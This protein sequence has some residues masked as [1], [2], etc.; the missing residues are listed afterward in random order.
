M[1]NNTVVLNSSAEFCNTIDLN[2]F[3]KIQPH[4]VLL[5]INRED[6]QV[7]QC[8]HN[9]SDILS[10]APEKILNQSI[11]Q[12]IPRNDL[13]SDFLLN[14]DRKWKKLAWKVESEE[15]AVWACVH[16]YPL[17]VMLEIEP[18]SETL[19]LS[20]LFDLQQQI[21]MDMQASQTHVSFSELIKT[22]CDQ[23]ML[24]T[25][26]DRVVIYQI[27]KDKTGLVIAETLKSGMDAYLGLR[28]PATDLPKQVH[29][30][31]VKQ[32]MRYIPCADATPVAMIPELNPLTQQ[33]TNVTE[34]YLRMV[35][36]VHVEYMKNMGI[37]SSISLGIVYDNQLWGIISC[38]HK[39]TTYYSVSHRFMLNLISN[40]LSSQLIALENGQTMIFRNSSLQLQ[41]SF[42]QMMFK[43]MS[44]AEV[45]RRHSEQILQLVN[46][47]GMTLFAGGDVHNFGKTPSKL[48]IEELVD[49]LQTQYSE[50]TY[51]TD[52]LAIEFPPAEKYKLDICGLISI[53][54]SSLS[55]YFVLFYRPEKIKEI[56]WAGDPA[57]A[58]IKD[59]SGYSPR[60]SFKRCLKIMKDHSEPWVYH[61]I[62]SAEFV[63]SI[64]KSKILKDYL[65]QQVSHDFLTG[66]L[67]RQS[68]FMMTNAYIA[69]ARREEKPV[70]MMMIDIDHFK[71]INDTYGHTI[72]DKVLVCVAKYLS[73][74][75]R[76][77]DGIFR[78][79]GEE[80]IVVLPGEGREAAYKRAEQLRQ[81][82][83]TM[84]IDFEGKPLPILTV[85]I[86]IAEYPFHGDNI[87]TL[88]DLADQALYEAKASG[89]D[90]VIIANSPSFS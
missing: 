10:V 58:V 29:E 20:E 33:V 17:Y 89:R 40:T 50:Q 75:F 14:K 57:T 16:Q 28:F 32:Y 67:N 66:L 30:M 60:D 81:N 47:G 80:F 8:S 42:S 26:S 5:I 49:F 27:D 76:E 24:I 55:R 25:D 72:G 37:N 77:Y 39:Q 12:F 35:V 1:D 63:A 87:Q 45:V 86:G 61:D 48:E 38:H 71:K 84:K 3:N 36:P 41:N 74:N 69:R 52:A 83:K 54:I 53:P 13:Y 73:D 19:N 21:L 44:L 22:I 51:V 82:L 65:Q 68:L 15:R 62:T 23:V 2:V 7:I 34:S 9:V 56:N 79:G 59:K 46:A 85:S 78:Y 11:Y 31:F 43:D 70:V 4:G 6:M 64:I 18:F 90:R 88:I